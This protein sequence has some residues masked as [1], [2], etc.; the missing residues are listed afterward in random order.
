[1]T[2][3]LTQL[4]GCTITIAT[5][6]DKVARNVEHARSLG[7]PSILTLDEWREYVPVAIVGGGPSLNETLDELRTF[8]NVI[9]AGSAHDHIVAHGIR[10]RWTVVC[11]ADPV[12]ANYLRTPVEGCTY[13]I[14]SQCDPAVFEALKG[15][16]VAVWHCGASVKDE[17][18]I[19]GGIER[20]S[21]G[22][23]CTVG[24]RS[25]VIAVLFGFRN[26]HLFGMDNCVRADQHHAYP[27]TDPDREFNET[28]VPLR[29]GDASGREFMVWPYH[30][31]Q[32]F[33]FKKLL[34][35]FA[36]RMS[37]TV[38]GD[39][40]LAELMRMGREQA[41]RQRRAA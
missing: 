26:L 16:R 41:E 37:V 9:A 6:L 25:I 38:H 32:L 7:L 14:A 11:D 12:A 39:G 21:I 19:F 3:T 40:V 20:F 4:E 8:E 34:K 33:D 35:A 5:P 31:G 28:P 15:H 27:F 30:V 10:P 13:L 24:M 17:T 29:L 18:E 2:G 1:M 23:G 22:G 36:N